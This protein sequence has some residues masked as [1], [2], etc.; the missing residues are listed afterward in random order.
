MERNSID[1]KD[2]DE[3]SFLYLEDER[4]DW[5]LCISLNE[6]LVSYADEHGTHGFLREMTEKESVPAGERFVKKILAASL[7]L[8]SLSACSGTAQP[9]VIASAV[10]SQTV[11]VAPTSSPLPPSQ[12]PKPQPA[13]E[14]QGLPIMPG[15]IAGEGD[16]EGYVFTVKA[17]PQEV[18]EYYQREL[19]RLGWQLSAQENT[20]SSMMLSFM[21]S[22]SATL[23]ISVLSN[24]EQALVLLAK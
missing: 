19:G 13:S 5:G 6:A 11:T 8:L 10:L 9:A 23:T 18:Q 7:I 21:D 24:G 15:A 3:P 12:T 17:T 1:E 2:G 14:W 20:G 22:D 16:E 4:G